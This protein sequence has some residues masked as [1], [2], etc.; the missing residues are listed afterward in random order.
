MRSVCAVLALVGLMVAG[1]GKANP[2]GDGSEPSMPRI[3]TAPGGQ[4]G[5]A[6][7][8]NGPGPSEP[9]ILGGGDSGGTGN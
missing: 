7:G 2:Q 8:T 4:D 1:C 5:G 9:N 3:S 6:T